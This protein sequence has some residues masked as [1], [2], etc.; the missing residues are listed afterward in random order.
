[1]K[2]Y[3]T[4]ISL[5]AFTGFYACSDEEL[6]PTTSVI[7]FTNLKVGNYWVYDWYEITPDGQASPFNLKDSLTIEGDT[8]I[9]GRRYLIRTGT[10]LGNLRRELVFDSANSL[11]TYPSRELIFTLDTSLEITKNFGP[12]EN[13]IAVGTYSLENTPTIVDVPAGLFECL[14][15]AGTI[16][17][18]QSGYLYGTR[19][20]DHQYSSTIGLVSMRTYYHSSPNDLEMRLVKYGQVN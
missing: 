14:T 9:S 2:N 8:L 4:F 6:P 5:V 13:I 10:F 17:S 12:E 11:Y 20:N 16:E 7:E 19:H 18:L 15:Y 1:M 3:I